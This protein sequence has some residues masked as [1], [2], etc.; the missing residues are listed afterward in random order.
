MFRQALFFPFFLNVTK[1][2][3]GPNS[4]HRG[5]PISQHLLCCDGLAVKHHSCIHHAS[6]LQQSRLVNKSG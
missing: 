6:Q 3:S 4:P 2:N 1:K 5:E